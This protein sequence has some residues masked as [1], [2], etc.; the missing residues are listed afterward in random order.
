MSA[1]PNPEE[2]E[3]A[4][5]QSGYTGGPEMTL[6]EHLMELKNRVIISAIAVV[7]GIIV[8]FIFWETIL[9]WLQAP[10]R[11]YDQ[12]F[13]L[14]SFSP[15]DRLIVLFKIGLYGGFMLASP[16]VVHQFLSFIVPGLTPQERKLI[17]PAMAGVAG[18]M[19]LGMAFAYWIILPVSLNFLLG[20]GSDEIVNVIGLQQYIDFTIR[21]IF[22]VGL[23]FELPMVL[24]LLAKL[25]MVNWRQ[26]LGFWRYAI[27]LVFVVGAV[28]T[29]TPDPLTQAMVAGPLF[30]LYFLGILFAYFVGPT[31][32]PKAA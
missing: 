23:A 24:A 15:T 28:A 4:P 6:I 19:L 21:V 26:L 20:F 29:P 1:Q 27:V 25:G 5:E 3:E 17:L 7:L 11:S 31:P 10:A 16:V 32:P 2:I 13:Q 8:C 22:F 18:F 9:G 30:V 12:D 14:A